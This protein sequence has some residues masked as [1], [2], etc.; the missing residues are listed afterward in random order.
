MDGG[1]AIVTVVL[2]FFLF[3]YLFFIESLKNHSKSLDNHKIKK[4]IVLDSK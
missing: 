1:F 4:L 3:I 2:S